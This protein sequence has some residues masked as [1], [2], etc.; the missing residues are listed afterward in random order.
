MSNSYVIN[1]E[2]TGHRDPYEELANGIILRAVEDYRKALACR[3]EGVILA[4][5]RF[6]TSEWFAILSKL[7]GQYIIDKIKYTF[8]R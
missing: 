6:F 3:D 7:D 5:E 4:I 2:N 8:K 1:N